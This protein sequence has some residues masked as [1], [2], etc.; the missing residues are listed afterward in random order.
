[1]L[2]TSHFDLLFHSVSNSRNIPAA[3][4]LKA[5]L[6]SQSQ[7]TASSRVTPASSR[8]SC[9]AS[10][11]PAQ[12]AVPIPRS[13][14]SKQS[15]EKPKLSSRMLAAGQSK[16]KQ[17]PASELPKS[18][19]QPSQQPPQLDQLPPLPDPA[20]HLAAPHGDPPNPLPSPALLPEGRKLFSSCFGT[21]GPPHGLDVKKSLEGC[22]AIMSSAAMAALQESI[23]QGQ[24]QEAGETRLS[25]STLEI[26]LASV[27]MCTDASIL[28]V[29]RAARDEVTRPGGDWIADADNLDAHLSSHWQQ[30]Q[31]VYDADFTRCV[32]FFADLERRDGKKRCESNKSHSRQPRWQR[33]FF[34]RL[35]GRFN[36]RDSAGVGL[37][38]TMLRNLFEGERVRLQ[39]RMLLRW[40]AKEGG[41]GR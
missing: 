25:L 29:T 40:R 2:C 15:S 39:P 10:S 13:S 20:S 16:A 7:A 3:S 33:R 23:A 37:C 21:Q 22:R 41:R 18:D 26:I 36:S 8:V 27:A 38:A 9:R 14:S 17:K 28:A 30:Q 5:A 35:N 1:M 11:A 34:S 32:H 31:H 19:G 4:D 12:S 6:A 24:L